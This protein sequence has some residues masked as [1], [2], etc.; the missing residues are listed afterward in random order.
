[1]LVLLKSQTRAQFRAVE[2]LTQQAIVT[3]V[4]APIA[5]RLAGTLT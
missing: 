1:V 4:V 3:A 2:T 5:F